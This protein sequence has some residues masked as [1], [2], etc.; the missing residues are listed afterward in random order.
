M[1]EWERGD[2]QVE[3]GGSVPSRDTPSREAG[4]RTHPLRAC[5]VL[6][7][8]VVW[9]QQAVTWVACLW[10][11]RVNMGRWVGGRLASGKRFELS[12]PFAEHRIG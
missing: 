10:R 8:W 2:K 5:L 12:E 3:G 4:F 1:T 9:I 6:G 11:E 7:G